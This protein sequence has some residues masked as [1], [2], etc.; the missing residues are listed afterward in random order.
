MEWLSSPQ[1]LLSDNNSLDKHPEP[2]GTVLQLAAALEDKNNATMV[3]KL[4]L[5][6]GAQVNGEGSYGTALQ[7]ASAR[8]I[9]SVV[10][11]LLEKGAKVDGLVGYSL[12]PLQGAS[13]QGNLAV[14]EFLL[15]KGACVNFWQNGSPSALQLAAS[16]WDIRIV[17]L[18]LDNGANVNAL[19]DGYDTVLQAASRTVLSLGGN[20]FVW[21]LLENSMKPR[22]QQRSYSADVRKFSQNAGIELSGET[23]KLLLD[24]GADITGPGCLLSEMWIASTQCNAVVVELLIERGANNTEF[25]ETMVEVLRRLQLLKSYLYDSDTDLYSLAGSLDTTSPNDND[26]GND[27]NDDD[28]GNAKANEDV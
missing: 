7:I 15:E 4:L 22:E 24:A 26:N 21:Q 25:G 16:R 28:N 20:Q 19:A 12:S 5:E 10:K 8:G 2:D 23:A 11:L 18:L 9:L 1:M 17:K 3:T 13:E 27:V 6:K 14:V